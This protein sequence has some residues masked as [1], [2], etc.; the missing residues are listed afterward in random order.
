[1]PLLLVC[2]NKFEFIYH[3]GDE[4]LPMNLLHPL[5]PNY[6]TQISPIRELSL[7]DK[8]RTHFF[9]SP[10]LTGLGL[11]SFTKLRLSAGLHIFDI[12]EEDVPFT[13]EDLETERGV[14]TYSFLRI[15]CK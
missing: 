6:I 1:M 9:S 13:G 11:K 14:G 8:C 7:F 10:N 12:Q 5:L 15:N 4:T 3:F 2:S